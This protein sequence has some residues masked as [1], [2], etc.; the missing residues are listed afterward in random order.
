MKFR[1]APSAAKFSVSLKEI[2][3]MLKR[4]HEQ[5]IIDAFFKRL[6][7]VAEGTGKKVYKF[8]FD[9]QD[10]LIGADYLFTETTMFSIAEFKYEENDIALERNKNLRHKMCLRLSN[11][12]DRRDEHCQCHF[13]AWSTCLI[14]F[15]LGYIARTMQFNNYSNEVC[16]QNVLGCFCGL[17]ATIPTIEG[18]INVD[19]FIKTFISGEIGLPFETFN[20]YINWLINDPDNDDDSGPN[21]YI[22]LLM[23]DENSEH[24]AAIEFCSLLKLKKWLDKNHPELET[25]VFN[26]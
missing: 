8:S 10:N 3:N 14:P 11:D 7:K 2:K 20:S 24:F 23:Q 18:R 26:P 16:N 1:I 21:E 25:G 15:T 22:E 13:I 17:E 9:G 5:S 12:A 19:L 6:D 4:K